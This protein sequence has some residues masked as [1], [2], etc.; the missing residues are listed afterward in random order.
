MEELNKTTIS[1]QIKK[2]QQ[3]CEC[4]G[5]DIDCPYCFGCPPCGYCGSPDCLDCKG[6]E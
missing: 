4:Y 5:M 6:G 2:N 1:D 3:Y